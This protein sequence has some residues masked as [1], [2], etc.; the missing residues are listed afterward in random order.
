M[1]QAEAETYLRGRVAEAARNR[2][3]A[4]EEDYVTRFVENVVV[5]V[6]KAIAENLMVP[7]V[8]PMT[9]QDSM[10]KKTKVQEMLER[11]LM[12]SDYPGVFLSLTT[13]QKGTFNK[14]YVF[15][16]NIEFQ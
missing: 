1:E 13:E 4:K 6:C 10:T 12:E 5:S 15:T 7:I 8:A 11:V 3:R 16:V 2:P 14:Y 9:S